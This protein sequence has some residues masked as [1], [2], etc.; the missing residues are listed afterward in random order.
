MTFGSTGDELTLGLLLIQLW[1]ST[2]MRKLKI[3][4]VV[5]MR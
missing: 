3:K 4:Q 5:I 2:V 1:I